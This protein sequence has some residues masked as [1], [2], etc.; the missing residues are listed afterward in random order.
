[1]GL[2]GSE[3]DFTAISSRPS[4]PC[5]GF[6]AVL[7]LALFSS[8]F[9]SLL[10]ITFSHVFLSAISVFDGRRLFYISQC[11]VAPCGS[12]HSNTS[13]RNSLWSVRICFVPKY[14]GI[15][16]KLHTQLI[17]LIYNL[18]SKPVRV[19]RAEDKM[20]LWDLV[21]L[22]MVEV[23]I[24]PGSALLFQPPGL[25]KIKYQSVKHTSQWH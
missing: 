20:F 19:S 3:R 22:S 11:F 8:I 5:S 17:L 6:P 18:V 7:T 4:R 24:V 21:R 14:P 13:T 15:C 2:C 9:F 25:D 23:Q 10:L 16:P 12:Y 1:M